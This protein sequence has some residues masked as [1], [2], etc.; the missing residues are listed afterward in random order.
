MRS[1]ASERCFLCL[2]FEDRHPLDSIQNI[3]RTDT[4]VVSMYVSSEAN[5]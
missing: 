1:C 2:V 3:P 4:S 5:R